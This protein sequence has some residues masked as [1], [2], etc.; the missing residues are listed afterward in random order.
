MEV[1][2]TEGYVALA[3]EETSANVPASV[4]DFIPLQPNAVPVTTKIRRM[5]SPVWT[6]GQK[7][8]CSLADAVAVVLDQCLQRSEV[9]RLRDSS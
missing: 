3:A 8:E 5:V 2:L 1:F 7:R 6:F 4:A 9:R